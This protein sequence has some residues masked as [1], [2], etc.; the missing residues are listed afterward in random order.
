MKSPVHHV[1]FSTSTFHFLVQMKVIF[2]AT[3]NRSG[4]LSEKAF[5]SNTEVTVKL[6]VMNV[7]EKSCFPLSFTFSRNPLNRSLPHVA[8]GTKLLCLVTVTVTV[9]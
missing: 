9:I 8:K 3:K 2:A 6:A 5:C 7:Q 4:S 1:K